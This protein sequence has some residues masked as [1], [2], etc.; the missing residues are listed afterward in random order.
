MD[1]VYNMFFIIYKVKRAK[2]VFLNQKQKAA[3]K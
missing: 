3:H 1:L 2:N